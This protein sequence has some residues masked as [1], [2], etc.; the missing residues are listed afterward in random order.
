MPEGKSRFVLICQQ[1]FACA[2]V[3]AV[4]VSAAG[5][6][7]LEIVSPDRHA[8]VQALGSSSVSLV[9]S[10]PVKPTVRTV[11]LAGGTAA[12][13]RLPS[14]SG[15]S[16]TDAQRIRVVSGTEPVTGFA[17]VGV[18]WADGEDIDAEQVLI[19]LRTRTDGVWSEWQQMHDD[20]DHAP[21]PGTE[22]EVKG[23]TDATVV[24]DVDDVQVRATSDSGT[25]PQELALAIVD[26]GED[27]APTE[28]APAIDTGDLGEGDSTDGTTGTPTATRSGDV[29]TLTAN[30]MATAPKPQIFSRAQWGADERLRDPGSLHYGEIDAGFVHHTVNANSYTKDQVPSIMRGIYAYHTQSRGWS[31]IGYNFLVDR[32]GQIWEGRYGGVDRPVVGA[33]TLGYNEESFAMSAIGNFE[34]VQPSEAMIQAYA[35]LF[36]WKLSLAGIAADDMKQWVDSRYFAAINGHRDAD[37][38]ACPGKYLYAKIPEIRKRAAAIQQGSETTEPP[39]PPPPAGPGAPLDADIS[40]SSW[41]DLVVRDSTT[42]HA[43]VIRTQGQFA[44]E[45][46]ATAGE[47]WSDRDLVVAA[48]DLD[49]DGV[50]DLVARKGATAESTLYLGTTDGGGSVDRRHLRPLR[51]PRPAR[52][53]GRLRRGRRQRPRGPP[54]GHRRAAA[55]PRTRRR[56]VR[57]GRPARYGLERLRPDHRRRRLRR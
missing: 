36:A 50:A 19:E 55:L 5:V 1:A 38:T 40:G 2:V 51:E 10:A 23:G 56:H 33:H 3:A 44:F 53:S 41:P 29:A 48:G 39:P 7:E 4:G 52:R 34:E 42:D 11:P 17:T 9:S 6:V 35:E 8:P 37:S 31:D 15:T 57:T 49:G 12:G 47:K 43:V 45:P 32:F 16:S 54:G 13:S 18:T 22:G 28:E 20:S 26:P 27:V 24:G 21:D 25:T 46:G 30:G 14:K